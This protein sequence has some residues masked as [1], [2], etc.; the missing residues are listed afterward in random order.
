MFGIGFPDFNSYRVYL[1]R[2]CIRY[3]DNLS[4]DS[5][6]TLAY[7]LHGAPTCVIIK[8]RRIQNEHYRVK[9]L[10][11][12]TVTHENNETETKFFE[13]NLVSPRSLH[14][15]LTR[16]KRKVK[17]V[18]YVLELKRNMLGSINPEML[19]DVVDVFGTYELEGIVRTEY[20]AYQS[21]KGLF[22]L[23]PPTL[24]KTNIA[25]PSS[26]AAKPIAVSPALL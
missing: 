11:L 9:P 1:R 19:P 15:L 10:A 23:T 4:P 22:H 18:L 17:N 3:S 24:S 12:N 26:E 5:W 2:G 21:P 13:K 8:E 7:H 16:T 25:F 6:D 20:H 14:F